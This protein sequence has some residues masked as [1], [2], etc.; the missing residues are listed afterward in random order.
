MAKVE[1]IWDMTWPQLVDY[2]HGFGAGPVT[3]YARPPKKPFIL[4]DDMYPDLEDRDKYERYVNRTHEIGLANAV[5]MWNKAAGVAVFRVVD[6]P[7]GADIIMKFTG[8]LQNEG[9]AAEGSPVGTKPGESRGAV[10]FDRDQPSGKRTVAHEL[11]HAVG[12]G[13]PNT[14]ATRAASGPTKDYADTQQLMSSAARPSPQEAGR[15]QELIRPEATP[16][17]AKRKR[18]RV[19][20]GGRQGGRA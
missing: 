11:G 3:V 13:H 17:P 10:W 2:A 4:A 12:L 15:V 20:P 6:A 7:E 14:G 8:D 19:E 5:R 9:A 16:E 18:K 1:P